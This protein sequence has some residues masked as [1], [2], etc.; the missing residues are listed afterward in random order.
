MVAFALVGHTSM[1]IACAALFL[2][3]T[4]VEATVTLR[5]DLIERDRA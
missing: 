4:L 1:T 5:M 3:S 2:A